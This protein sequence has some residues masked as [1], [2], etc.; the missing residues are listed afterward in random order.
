MFLKLVQEKIISTHG[1]IRN[2]FH[3]IT[4]EE[5]GFDVKMN[6]AEKDLVKGMSTQE[7]LGNFINSEREKKE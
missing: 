5:V 4:T 1:S 6:G 3:K 2:S 7:G